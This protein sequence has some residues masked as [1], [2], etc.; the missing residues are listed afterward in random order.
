ML[1]NEDKIAVAH[2]EKAKWEAEK[3]RF[4]LNARVYKDLKDD[5]RYDQMVKSITDL[6]KGIEIIDKEIKELSPKNGEQVK[7]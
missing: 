6:H 7:Q 1:R 4:E 5:E 2:R 3:Y